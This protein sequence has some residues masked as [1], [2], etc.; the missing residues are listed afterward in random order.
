MLRRISTKLVLAVLV[1]VVLPFVVFAFYLNEQ[2]ADRVRRDVV[3]QSS[4]NHR[5]N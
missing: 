1:A 4:W 2:V 3:R 5:E